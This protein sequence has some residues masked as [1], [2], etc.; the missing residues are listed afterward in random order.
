MT[1]KT[2]KTEAP[3]T[4]APKA[5]KAP[6]ARA[7]KAKP[8]TTRDVFSL[9]HVPGAAVLTELVDGGV[10]TAPKLKPGCT[11]QV[12]YL[13]DVEHPLA[14][15]FLHAR[16]DGVVLEPKPLGHLDGA[17]RFV[18]TTAA[19]DVVPGA[20]K[21]EYWFELKTADGKTLWDSNWGKNHW[22]D[23]EGATAS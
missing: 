14:G 3:K 8:A 19:V 13:K 18:R 20:H 10:V 21:L 7:V 4:D 12:A 1:R 22:V 9:Q 5:P 6:R 17:G 15:A 11:V 16:L 23:V 2:T